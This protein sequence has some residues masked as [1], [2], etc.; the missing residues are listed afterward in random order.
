[1][2]QIYI[3][4]RYDRREEMAGYAQELRDKGFIVDCRWLLGLHQLHTGSEK[5]DIDSHPE[6][7]VTLEAAPFAQDDYEDLKKSDTIVLFSERP[8][9]HSKRGGRHVEFGMAL[10]WGHRL[11]VIGP[12][13]NVFHCLP[14]VERFDTWREFK[15]FHV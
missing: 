3:A 8:E 15:K 9:S 4:G 2:K 5:V 7:G 10:A 13:E 14:E 12:R 11:I 1:M 6:H